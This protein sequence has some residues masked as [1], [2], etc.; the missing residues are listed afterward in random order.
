MKKIIAIISGF[1][2]LSG[3]AL[4]LSPVES[5]GRCQNKIDILIKIADEYCRIT[6]HATS[7]PLLHS[8]NECLAASNAV[9]AKANQCLQQMG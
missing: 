8:I 9:I 5:E 6:S 4:A 2:I 3:Q 7:D 1:F